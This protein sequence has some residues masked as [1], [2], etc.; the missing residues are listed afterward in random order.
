MT[1]SQLLS[2]I[3][4]SS[5]YYANAEK[6]RKRINEE[7]NVWLSGLE[8]R[9][10]GSVAQLTA[11]HGSDVDVALIVP[12]ARR[13]SDLSDVTV[14]CVG[15]FLEKCFDGCKV[16][17]CLPAATVPVVTLDFGGLKCDVIW[18]NLQTGT[19]DAC[20]CTL[21]NQCGWR[22]S[23]E[24]GGPCDLHHFRRGYAL[25][26]HWYKLSFGEASPASRGLLNN[27]SLVLLYLFHLIEEGFIQSWVAIAC[28]VPTPPHAAP[29]TPLAL[30]QGFLEFMVKLQDIDNLSS[31][32]FSVISGTR[33]V[34]LAPQAA[35]LW[36]SDPSTPWNNTASAVTW[37][38]WTA[39]LE[40]ARKTLDKLG[41]A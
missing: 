25:V 4:P 12:V 36:I 24:G 26:K 15:K 38:G 5:E 37:D 1:E 31:T 2:A 33:E 41:D 40:K 34:P 7:I 6:L 14:E 39:I 9:L 8:V 21:L 18:G 32:A 13:L 22:S 23:Q 20:I 10:F 35:A 3:L 16:I 29:A 28:G 17:R 27:I 30:F 11:L 19:A